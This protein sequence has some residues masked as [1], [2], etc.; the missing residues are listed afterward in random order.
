MY[1][2]EKE[3]IVDKLEVRKQRAALNKHENVKEKKGRKIKREKE[4][5]VRLIDSI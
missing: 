5:P 4:T 3:G 1:E 2:K